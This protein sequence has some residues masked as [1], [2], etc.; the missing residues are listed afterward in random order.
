MGS[1]VFY[2]ILEAGN[3]DVNGIYAYVY[4]PND[5]IAEYVARDFRWILM[6]YT[7]PAVMD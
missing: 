6:R 1:H 5:E 4:A 2:H 3:P 7:H